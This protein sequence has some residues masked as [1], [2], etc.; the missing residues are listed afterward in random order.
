[1]TN[2]EHNYPCLA[3]CSTYNGT[4]IA[5]GRNAT[6]QG[7]EHAVWQKSDGQIQNAVF[8]GSYDSAVDEFTHRLFSVCHID[9]VPGKYIE[10]GK[11]NYASR[12]G[13]QGS[14]SPHAHCASEEE[15]LESLAMDGVSFY[16]V[17]DY[18]SSEDDEELLLGQCPELRHHL[19]YAMND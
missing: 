3:A 17:N 4:I 18:T 14:L 2:I 5:L 7:L 13:G 10:R 15:L 11:G 9:H 8:C 1:M 6:I 12:C 16:T 19:C